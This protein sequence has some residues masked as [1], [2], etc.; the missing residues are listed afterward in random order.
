MT[1]L[2]TV[3]SAFR[4]ATG[5]AAA[6]WAEED[7]RLPAR[8]AASTPAVGVLGWTPPLDVGPPCTVDSPGGPAIVTKLPGP[9][10]CWLVIGPSL[11]PAASL[12]NYLRFLL[13]VVSQYR[14]EE[15]TSELQSPV[16]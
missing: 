3:L 16:H 10:R 13:P 15:H 1:D 6:V 11:D 2:Q 4:D 12:E 14:S 5:C 9:R 7:G 8:L